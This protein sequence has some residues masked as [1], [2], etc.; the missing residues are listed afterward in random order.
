[1]LDSLVPNDISEK[2][3]NWGYWFVTHKLLLRRLLIIALIAGNAAL[4]GFSG[5]AFFTDLSNASAR[6]Q[7]LQELATSQLNPAVVAAQAPQ[8]ITSSNAQVLVSN[9]KYDFV[10]TIKNPNRY[11]SARF[12]YRFV[13]GSFATPPA[14]G[15][16]LP[17]EEK[18][19]VTLGQATDTRP[20]G[21]ALE[22]SNIIWQRVDRHTIPDWMTFASQHLNFPITDISYTPGI[23]ITPGKPT[24][25]RTSFTVANNTGFGYYDVR[26]LVLMYRGAAL[27]AVNTTILPTFAPGESRSAEVTWYEDFGAISQIKV[28]P[29]IDITSSASYIRAQ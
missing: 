15:F 1:M 14:V 9:G 11:F 25:G 5:Y 19:V 29:E 27:A 18:F 23:E 13:A 22:I 10:S 3:L 26:L 28:I 2:Q 24:I 21:A 6:N 4:F 8:S 7:Q 16:V 20:S 17:G 12:S